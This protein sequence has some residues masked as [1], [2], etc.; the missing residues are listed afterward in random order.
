[1]GFELTVFLLSICIELS[2]FIPFI[3]RRQ[4]A[5]T[6]LAVGVLVSGAFSGA[7]F[8]AAYPSL[9][10][11]SV[12]IVSMYR[13]INLLRLIN[14]RMHDR[15]LYVS[16]RRTAVTLW[17][18]A[19]LACIAIYVFQ[20]LSLTSD[21]FFALV[22]TVLL[23]VGV[24]VLLSTARGMRHTRTT[25]T[26]SQL[27]TS[28]LPSVT[29][30]IPARNETFDL[31]ECLDSVLR[32][33]YPKLEILVLDDCSQLRRTP[34]II[35]SY[36]HKGVRFVKGEVVAENWLAKNQA[37][38]KLLNE[39]NGEIII[40]CGV[41]IRFE[42]ESIYQLVNIMHARSK[43]MVSVLPIRNVGKKLKYAPIQ[44]LR[45]M[46][47]LGPP[48][49]LFN[50][51]PVLSSLWAIYRSDA[52]KIGGFKAVSRTILPERYFA[53]QMVAVDGY[54]FLRASSGLPLYSQKSYA[55]QRS[56]SV[57]VRYPQLRKRPETV[58]LLSMIMVALFILPYVVVIYA[59]LHGYIALALA[60]LAVVAS[61][62]ISYAI[63]SIGTH[64]MSWYIAPFLHLPAVIMDVML[65]HYSMY[66]YEFSDVVWK[67]RN[68]CI[69]VMHVTSKLPD[70]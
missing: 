5:R 52:K 42:K 3:W 70:A 31:E 43:R 35:K 61:V 47:E 19:L 4:T 58:L 22:F 21:V 41:D 12:A 2:L 38:N 56:T 63:I 25:A 53:R 45:Y 66:R 50:R 18:F 46:W 17:V 20:Q 8:L 1:M 27:T 60:F 59:L 39:A 65:L 29:V 55:A 44:S 54:S 32:S 7:Y 49:R 15:Y 28:D 57:R 69:P 48:R 62:N 6:M 36:A 68:V 11:V 30:A 24:F 37:Y 16:T 10:T 23:T 40:F 13:I 64:T 33:T 14:N 26:V 67:D 34:E 9:V 51:P